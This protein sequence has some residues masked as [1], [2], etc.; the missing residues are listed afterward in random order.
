MRVSDDCIVIQA[1]L[2]GSTVFKNDVPTPVLAR[3]LSL[4]VQSYKKKWN[5]TT[6]A[7]FLKVP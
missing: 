4:K 3:N 6:N 5:V 7:A 1:S 2:T